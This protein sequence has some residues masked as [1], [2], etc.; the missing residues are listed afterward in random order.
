[1]RYKLKDR[2]R[3]Y[4]Q[5]VRWAGCRF[6]LSRALGLP[7]QSVYQWREGIPH[8]HIDRLVVMMERPW[9]P[10]NEIRPTLRR[11]PQVSV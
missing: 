4:Q 2:Q 1:M 8:R 9:E 7:R 6:Q 10:L 11:K 3:L 5:A